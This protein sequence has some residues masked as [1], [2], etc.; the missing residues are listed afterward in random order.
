MLI[1]SYYLLEVS[2][3]VAF[4]IRHSHLTSEITCWRIVLRKPFEN[5]ANVNFVSWK[6]RKIRLP[7]A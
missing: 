6:L 1:Y 5:F 3:G 7:I 4:F 2:P